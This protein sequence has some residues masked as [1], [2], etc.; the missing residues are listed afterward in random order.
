MG[1]ERGSGSAPSGRGRPPANDPELVLY[2]TVRRGSG[3]AFRRLLDLHDPGM[4]RVASWYVPDPARGRALVR[5]T[6]GIALDGLNMFT[7]H[8]TF[9]A[10]L[11]GILVSVGR[12]AR[13]PAPPPA[14]VPAVAAA[15]TGAAPLDWPTLP[16]DPRWTPAAWEVFRA[17][18]A[19]LPLDAAE[20][21]RLHDAE[22]WPLVEVLDV[23]QH[24]GAEGAAL[25]ARGRA[26]LRDAAADAVGHPGGGAVTD[27]QVIGLREVLR[28]LAPGAVEPDA[29][30]LAVFRSWRSRRD[31]PAL[32]RVGGAVT[33]AR[34]VPGPRRR[35]R[36]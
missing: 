35:A 12:G 16:W 19:D 5:E 9:R 13:A 14:P 24:T 34:A 20:V 11:F 27:P 32:R 29:A 21:V 31:I 6:W 36:R 17:A 8:T 10:W 23:L 15:A 33:A 4:R 30:L 3:R 28:G 26:R 25:L 22:G 2:E 7:W 1:G 18:L